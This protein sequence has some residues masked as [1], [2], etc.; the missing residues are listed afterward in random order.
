MYNREW[1]EMNALY[2]DYAYTGS[3]IAC[4]LSCGAG[5][6]Y[7]AEGITKSYEVGLEKVAI[8]GNKVLSELSSLNF[9]QINTL[10]ASHPDEAAALYCLSVTLVCAMIFVASGATCKALENDEE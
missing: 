4:G 6:L 1:N 8:T 9:K 5:I 7:A 3:A 2:L 10:M